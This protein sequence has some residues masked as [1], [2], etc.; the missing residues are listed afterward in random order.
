MQG[1]DQMGKKLIGDSHAQ[2]YVQDPCLQMLTG[3]HIHF[4]VQ[5]NQSHKFCSR[6]RVF[7]FTNSNAGI[8]PY[9]QCPNHYC[10]ISLCCKSSPHCL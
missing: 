6:R 4:K 7:M 9:F 3:T 1:S 10:V 2:R 8:S 5:R